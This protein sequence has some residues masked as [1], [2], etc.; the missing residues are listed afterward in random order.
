MDV[1]LIPY[2]LSAIGTGGN[3]TVQVIIDVR[4]LVRTRIRY[5]YDDVGRI[6]KVIRE[7]LP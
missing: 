4:S 1:P 6:K 2:T 7:Q 5:E 3:T